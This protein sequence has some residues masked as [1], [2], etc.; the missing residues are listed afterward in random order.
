M[1]LFYTKLHIGGIAYLISVLGCVLCVVLS[2]AIHYHYT[3][4][5]VERWTCTYVAEALYAW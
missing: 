1:I 4:V 5:S 2:G 3:L